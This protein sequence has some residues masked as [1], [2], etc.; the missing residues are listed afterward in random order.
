MVIQIRIEHD[1][2]NSFRTGENHIVS[3]PILTLAQNVSDTNVER[4]KVLHGVNAHM[5]CIKRT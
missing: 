5:V 2:E 4:G 3:N 1:V